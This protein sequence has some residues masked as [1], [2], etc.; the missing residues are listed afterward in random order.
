[1][2]KNKAE[3]LTEAKA[4]G[5][6]VTE[7]QTV[8]EI[9]AAIK[10]AQ[11]TK[12]PVVAKAGKRSAKSIEEQAEKE[13]KEER[14]VAKTDSEAKPK[15]HQKP[16]RSKLERR[17]KSYRQK[18]EVIDRNKQ[19]S[20]PDGVVLA[21][22]TSPVKFDATVE[23]HVRLNV[24]PKQADQNIR[25]SVVLPAGSGKTLRVAVIGEAD[26]VAAAKKAGADIA[27]GEELL[28][29]L[30]KGEVGFDVLIAVPSMMPKLGKYARILGPKGLMPNPKSGTV[31]KDVSKA[32]TEAKAGKIEYR[33]DESG[34]VHVP[35]GKVSFG[36]EKVTQ[37]AQAI[38]SSIKSN[39]PSS[40]KS[41]FVS[42]IY[43]T[44][45]MGPSVP[46]TTSAV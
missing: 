35:I 18:A 6:E 14:K 2:A 8:V 19:Y 9:T 10:A 3:L 28:A 16:T 36:A 15:V 45:S 23:L 43:I 30:D 13:A 20:L 41:A 32:V 1:M 21:L 11:D 29:T 38:L 40:I 39:K 46:V 4:L 7:K 34:I 27:Q 12:K 44:T 37:N 31:T 33:V 25:D 26:D 22:K 42:S 17:S 5:L 24:D